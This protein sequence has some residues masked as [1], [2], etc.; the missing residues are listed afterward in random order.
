MRHSGR[1]ILA[2]GAVALA[3]DVSG[4]P[5]E[6][7]DRAYMD[8]LVAERALE[9]AGE[10]VP[11]FTRE[12][13]PVARRAFDERCRD[14]ILGD[15]RS[16]KSTA[17]AFAPKQLLEDRIRTMF[18][19]PEKRRLLLSAL[20]CFHQRIGRAARDEA[21]TEQRYARDFGGVVDGLRLIS[22]QKVARH[23]DEGAGRARAQVERPVKCDEKRVAL[24][25]ACLLLADEVASDDEESAYEASCR[26]ELGAAVIEGA[27]RL[28]RSR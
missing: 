26:T 25:T 7:C 9:L 8:L 12:R 4:A 23:A 22:L 21:R 19:D 1:A 11:T 10:D 16:F 18:E 20:V 2:A 13:V 5:G 15:P 27:R 28:D 3:S 24:L 14:A 6:D 17:D